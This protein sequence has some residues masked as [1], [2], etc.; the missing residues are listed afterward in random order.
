ML[1]EQLPTLPELLRALGFHGV[2]APGEPHVVASYAEAARLAGDDVVVIG[3]D[4]R[5]A[6][7]VDD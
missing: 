1:R 4:K 2:V 7:L 5:Y 6:Q 3:I